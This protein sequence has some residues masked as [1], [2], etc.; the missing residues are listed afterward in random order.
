MNAKDL[1]CLCVLAGGILII[2]SQITGIL[3]K[4]DRLIA[5]LEDRTKCVRTGK[6]NECTEL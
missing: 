2:D 4:A 1:L 5:C 3:Q 6:V